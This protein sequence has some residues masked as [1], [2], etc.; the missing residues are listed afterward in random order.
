MRRGKL[1]RL[2]YWGGWLCDIMRSVFTPAGCGIHL[3]ML[4]VCRRRTL[5]ACLL[6]HIAIS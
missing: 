1:S 5:S 4:E 3:H 6:L 2:L